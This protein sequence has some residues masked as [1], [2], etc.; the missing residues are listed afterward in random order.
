[1]R[2]EISGR[3]NIST[4]DG[5]IWD[6][7]DLRLLADQW[8]RR[9]T[10][11]F[12][13][14]FPV[15]LL[16]SQKSGCTSAVKWFFWQTGLL[17]DARA[18]SGW[19]HDYE[20]AIFKRQDGYKKQLVRHLCLGKKTLIKFTRDP[21]Q[22]AVSS[23]LMLSGKPF[24]NPGYFGHA[25]WKILRSH[26][27]GSP[28]DPRGICFA[29]F[30]G[31]LRDRRPVLGRVNAHFAQQFQIEEA[32]FSIDYYRLENMSTAFRS[33]EAALQ[34]PHA[35]D[36]VYHSRHHQRYDD[37][38]HEDV[39]LLKVNEHTFAARRPPHFRCFYSPETAELVRE[40]FW[41]DFNRYDYPLALP[42]LA[43]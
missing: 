24:R 21:F 39:S 43:A 12:V 26:V 4:D 20:N 11:L 1:M 7:E 31:Y 36:D 8:V 42:P 10:P 30:L 23:F 27:Y 34:I 13:P 14:E 19:V 28:D 41:E 37:S 2:P 15:I 32:M 6:P 17:D 22:R 40:V 3:E 38:L 29:D 25:E 5:S 16:Y 18:F 9:R 35:P 33:I